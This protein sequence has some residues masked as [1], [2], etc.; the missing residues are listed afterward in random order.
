MIE[1]RW[2]PTLN[3]ETAIEKLQL[4]KGFDSYETLHQWSIKNTCEFWSNAWDDNNVI[5]DKGSTYFVQGSDFI[6]SQFFPQ[7]RLNVAENLL[8]HGD[9]DEVAIVSI[10][11]TGVRAEITWAQLRIKVA[12]TA[13]AMRAEGVVAGDRVVAWVPNVTETIIYGLGALSIGA[14]VSTASPDF[15]PHA[16]EDR[17]GQV[18]PK[19]LLAADGYNYNGKYFDC[20]EK[21]LDIEKMLPTL[22]KTVRHVAFKSWYV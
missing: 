11:E 1:K 22:N 20:T 3:G 6:S 12:A 9:A 13:A 17:F 7:A 4:E 19:L 21:S 14:I 16:V 10:L 2:E 5:G 15:A 8:A 18:E